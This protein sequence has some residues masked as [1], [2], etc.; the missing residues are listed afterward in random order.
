MD[1][2]ALDLGF[3]KIYWYSIFILLGLLVGVT[4]ILREAKRKN[5]KEDFIVD[6]LFFGILFA[7]IG[8]RLY[9]VLFNLPYYLNHPSEIIMIWNGGLAIHGGII[10]G[11]ITIIYM[12]KKYKVDIIK[13]LDILVI[14]L[15]IGQAIGRWGNFFNSEAY[16]SIVSLRALQS[17]GIPKFIIDGMYI[18]GSY[19]HPTFLYESIL[20]FIGF[21]ILM[22]NR[23]SFKTGGALGFYLVWYGAVRFFIESLRLDS[24]M[25]GSLKVAQIISIIFII[26]G[27][28][29][30]FIYKSE[31]QKNE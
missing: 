2:I 22:I 13:L 5:I 16:G 17:V 12:C 3:I 8:A 23:K 29:Y 19:H 26:I 15:I 20:C 30:L 24:L 14:G 4:I 21:I 10:F 7:I 18:D 27:I 11:L 25:L 6:T 1:S 9:Y 31:V 28:Y